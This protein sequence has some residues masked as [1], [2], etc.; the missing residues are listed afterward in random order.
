MRAGTLKLCCRQQ[1]PRRG[2]DSCPSKVH[3]CTRTHAHVHCAGRERER[4][5][6]R[7]VECA[8]STCTGYTL[9]WIY[10]EL[11]ANTWPAG[12]S[13]ERGQSGPIQTQDQGWP[14][15]KFYLFEAGML[16]ALCPTRVSCELWIFDSLCL[17]T[18]QRLASP[19]GAQPRGVSLMTQP[20]S[21]RKKKGSCGDTFYCATVVIVEEVRGVKSQQAAWEKTMFFSLFNGSHV[22]K[23]S[24]LRS[25]FREGGKKGEHYEQHNSPGW[26]ETASAENE[27]TTVKPAAAHH[28]CLCPPSTNRKSRSSSFHMQGL[29]VWPAIDHVC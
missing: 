5:N 4:E 27:E 26:D 9:C 10:T 29:C 19:V 1:E 11:T 28:T 20:R 18:W 22:Y 17:V 14:A 24:P 21:R 8:W 16:L 6:E 23:D 13:P 3:S 15:P 7:A 25:F 2:E 12:R